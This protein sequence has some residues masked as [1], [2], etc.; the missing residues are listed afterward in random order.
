M[1]N[2][3]RSTV[4]RVTGLPLGKAE[5]DVKSQLL[6]EIRD[7]LRNDKQQDVEAIVACVPSCDGDQT[8]SALVEFKGG[9]P[10][11]LSQLERDPLS[12]WQVE[13]GDEDINFDRH[14]FGFTQLYS[15]AP[16]QPVAAEY[17]S[18]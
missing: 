6:E 2:N 11:F 8:S 10:K 15:T 3:A 4:F 5:V 7:L 1:A 9:M 12:N 16:G 13:M 18:Y 17:G 14:F